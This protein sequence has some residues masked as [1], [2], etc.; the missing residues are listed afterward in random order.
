[1]SDPF[2]SRRPEG[3]RASFGT[4]TIPGWAVLLATM[5]AVAFGIGLFLLSAS[6]VLVL[7]PL[8][9]VGV[10]IARWRFRRALR[11][12]AERGQGGSIEAEYHVIDIHREP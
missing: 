3:Y 6:I 7:T 1:M 4:T 5:I 9:V 12:A 8:V 10:L 11:R 2:H